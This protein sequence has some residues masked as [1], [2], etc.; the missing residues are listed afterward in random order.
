MTSTAQ[1]ISSHTRLLKTSYHLRAMELL[2]VAGMLFMFSSFCQA[3]PSDKDIQQQYQVLVPYK[4]HITKRLE[5]VSP[6]LDHISQQLKHRSLPNSLILV[7]ML[8]SSYNPQA[9][10]HANA[11]GL[12]QLIP[13]TAIRFGLKVD[14]N[15]DERFDTKAS[16]GAALDYLSFLYKK[17]DQNISLTLAAYN[18]GEGRVG[19]A[20]KKAGT[21]NFQHLRLPQ[22]TRQYVNRFHALLKLVELPNSNFKPNFKSEGKSF[23][24]RFLFANEAHKP[25]PL[26]DFSRLPPL[27]NL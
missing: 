11:A 13:A 14:S 3:R 25:K 12:W 8:E 2:L 21:S 9:V 27:V 18:A 15:K 6:T 26:I 1:S 23:Q 22:E 20:I 17:F 10:S 5:D 4:K 16:T 24:P 19:R 7:P